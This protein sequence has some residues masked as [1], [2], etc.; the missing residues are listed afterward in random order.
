[1]DLYF[2]MKPASEEGRCRKSDVYCSKAKRRIK[3]K[4]KANDNLAA[5]CMFLSFFEI[6]VY[7]IRNR[8][9]VYD[10]ERKNL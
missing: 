3:A 2:T 7:T 10:A 8:N 5:G 4:I 6:S 9:I 1:M